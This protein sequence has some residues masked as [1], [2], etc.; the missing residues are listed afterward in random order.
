MIVGEVQNNTNVP[1]GLVW[2]DAIVYD[3]N[4]K[5]LGTSDYNP[6]ELDVIPPGGKSPYITGS[7]WIGATTCKLQAQGMESELPRRDLII[8]SHERFDDGKFLRIRGEVQNI[9]TTP[10]DHVELV[11]TFYDASGKVI[12]VD[13]HHTTLD[14]IPA[15]GTSPFEL[16]TGRWYPIDRYEIQVQAR[17]VETP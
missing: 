10:A 17:D 4:N 2:I 16:T 7:E 11:G 12:D 3:S 13:S 14:T 6:P 15:G 9:G 5:V 8:L 1:M